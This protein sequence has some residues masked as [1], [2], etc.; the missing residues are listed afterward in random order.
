LTLDINQ[1]Y[2]ASYSGISEATVLSGFSMASDVLTGT[3]LRSLAASKPAGDFLE[4]DTGTGMSTSWILDGMDSESSLTSIDNE[5]EFLNIAKRFLGNDKR[6]Q[7]ILTDGSKWIEEHNYLKFDYIFA[8]T[9]P[10]KYFMVAEVLNML[11]KGGYF[12]IDDMLPQPNWPEGHDQKVR[13]LIKYL[14]SRNDLLLTKLN[15]ATGIIVAVKK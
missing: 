13:D 6:L 8:D 2:P 14:D 5:L 12:I 10:G 1:P 7:L 3:L 15:W 11:N 9:W 4:L